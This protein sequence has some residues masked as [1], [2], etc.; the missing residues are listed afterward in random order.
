MA[1]LL[2]GPPAQRLPKL[3]DWQPRKLGEDAED[4]SE[5][6]RSPGLAVAASSTCRDS[7]YH[8]QFNPNLV[9]ILSP[10]FFFFMGLLPLLL[11][12]TLPSHQRALAA[13]DPDPSGASPKSVIKCTGEVAWVRVAPA[14]PGWD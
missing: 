7:S 5:A 4:G 2:L 10:F 13:A 8:P 14:S 3:E 12:P 1:P 9:S 6:P 11:C